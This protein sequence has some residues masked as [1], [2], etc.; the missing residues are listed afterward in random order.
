MDA[1]RPGG[2]GRKHVRDPSSE[3]IMLARDAA[4][5]ARKE[6]ARKGICCRT[7]RVGEQE[8]TSLR[9]RAHQE[10][11]VLIVRT[12]DPPLREVLIRTP[13]VSG[14]SALAPSGRDYEQIDLFRYSSARSPC[15]KRVPLSTRER[16]W[17]H[18]NGPVIYFSTD[19][20]TL[21]SGHQ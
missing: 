4:G 14:S 2:E 13:G 10:R 15:H 1:Q 12:L 7:R 8:P 21:S 9:G 20:W 3:R 5:T 19:H 11:H 18:E 17:I 16:H 6:A